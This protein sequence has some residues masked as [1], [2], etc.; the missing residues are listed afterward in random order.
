MDKHGSP[1]NGRARTLIEALPYIRMWAGKTMVVK[2]GGAAM[3]DPALQHSVM[4]DLVLMHYV[5]VRVVMVHGGGPKISQMM[6]RLGHQPQFLGGLRVT[7]EATM[8]IVQMVL[9]GSVSQELVALLNAEGVPAVGLSGHDANIVKAHKLDSPAG[10]LGFVGEVS[11]VDTRLIETL[12]VAGYPVVLSSIGAGEGRQSFNINADAMACAV[13]QALNAEKLI[14][15]SDVPGVLADPA[16]E[17]S[18]ISALATADA[19]KLIEEGTVSEGMIPKLEAAVDAIENGV[20]SV[21][22]IDGRMEH[23]LI[24]E[25][26][27]DEGVGTMIV[28]EEGAEHD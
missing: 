19:L 2:Y 16:D 21:H 23:S 27:T 18:V 6:E 1:A 11:H 17:A 24:M 10:D 13:A 28:A 5:G 20:N 22:M 4:R 3:T 25:L 26:F 14:V 15:L 7:D 9:V 12:T 8:E